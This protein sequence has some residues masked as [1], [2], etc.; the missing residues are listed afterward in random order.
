METRKQELAR[1]DSTLVR[2]GGGL[3]SLERKVRDKLAQN[4]MDDTSA[5]RISR[6]I[7]HSAREIDSLHR[8]NKIRIG[9]AVVD[10]SDWQTLLRALAYART[11]SKKIND[12]I[13]FLTD[14]V[15]QNTVVKIDQD[16]FFPPGS[17]SVSPQMALALEK[18][19]EPA[20]VEIDRFTRKYPD[21]P[22]S[23][24][25]T[26]RGYAD[27]TTIAEGS[28]LYRELTQRLRLSGKQP[29]NADL[30]K[31]L[32]QARAREVIDLFKK[33]AGERAGSQG[34]ISHILYLHEGKGEAYPNP[35]ITNY[36]LADSRRRV[37]Y[38]F[39]GV[40]PE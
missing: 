15:S 29:D 20:A 1:V 13:I 12:K 8:A 30:N 24:V 22:L 19:F 17:Y 7:H 16:V 31:E 26:A 28:A 6:F 27:G 4:E 32:S 33:F 23:L 39:W 11:S 34:Y 9:E 10:R 40:F 21:F 18:L 14:L 35:K 37:V 3:V 2:Q 36:T 38:L 5:A 25:I